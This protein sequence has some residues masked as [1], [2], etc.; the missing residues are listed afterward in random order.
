LSQKFF[1]LILFLFLEILYSSKI[2]L[3]FVIILASE[4]FIKLLVHLLPHI[5]ISQGIANKSFH[6]SSHNFAVIKLHDFSRASTTNIQFESQATISF[7]T[8]K[9]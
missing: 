6:K 5:K 7:L 2:S 9:L 3:E 4:F 1:F 8:G